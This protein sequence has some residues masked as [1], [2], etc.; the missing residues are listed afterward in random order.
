MFPFCYKTGE[1]NESGCISLPGVQALPPSGGSGFT[2]LVFGVQW[3]ELTLH[4][5]VYS[6]LTFLHSSCLT[7]L[8]SPVATDLLQSWHLSSSTA[9]V[10]VCVG[11]K[12]LCVDALMHILLLDWW[13]QWTQSPDTCT[14]TCDLNQTI[15]LRADWLAHWSTY[16]CLVAV[17]FACCDNT[18][19]SLCNT[20]I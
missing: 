15:L 8:I 13:K 4:T 9:I 10:M 7:S 19:S 18:E 2:C 3:A 14:T 11:L 16:I 20:I 17:I 6:L 1:Q 12:C 5:F